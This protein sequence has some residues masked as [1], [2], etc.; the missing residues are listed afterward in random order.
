MNR[1][2]FTHA[3]EA[4]LQL[5]GRPFSRAAMLA[6]VD[7]C[8]SLIADNLDVGQWADEIWAAMGF[9]ALA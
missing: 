8:W 1:D 6:F 2:N 7:D 3:L 9:E 4:E 5:A